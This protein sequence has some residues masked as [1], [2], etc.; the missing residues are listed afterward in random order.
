MGSGSL[1]FEIG[2]FGCLSVSDNALDYPPESFFSYTPLERVEEALRERN[3]PTTGLRHASRAG[4]CQQ[5]PDLRSC[6]KY[7]ARKTLEALNNQLVGFLRQTLQPAHVSLWLR[8]ATPVN[9]K[10]EDQPTI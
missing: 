8:P 2:E 10:Q 6:S 7:D 4:Y 1:R 5:A 9:A 3:L